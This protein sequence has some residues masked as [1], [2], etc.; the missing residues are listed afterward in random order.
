M[1]ER[2]HIGVKNP[3]DREGEG[4]RGKEG[5]GERGRGGEISYLI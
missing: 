3:N 5:E 2:S 1:K 4:E